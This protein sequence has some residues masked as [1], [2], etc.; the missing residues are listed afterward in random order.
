MRY[1]IS[2]I[3]TVTTPKIDIFFEENS[4]NYNVCCMAFVMTVMTTNIIQ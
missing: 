4:Y 2:N 3:S 1:K